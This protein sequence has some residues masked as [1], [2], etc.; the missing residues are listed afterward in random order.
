MSKLWTKLLKDLQQSL[1]LSAVTPLK[2][3]L[4]NL[5]SPVLH[6]NHHRIIIY[7]HYSLPSDPR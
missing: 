6:I 3:K 1:G 5:S 4:T 7:L 2:C